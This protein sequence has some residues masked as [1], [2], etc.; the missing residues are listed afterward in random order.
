MACYWPLVQLRNVSFFHRAAVLLDAKKKMPGNGILPA[1]I[2][3]CYFVQ[4]KSACPPR[5]AQ[6]QPP[7]SNP[8]FRP[9]FGGAAPS[10]MER[11]AFAKSSLSIV[12]LTVPFTLT[13]M[14]APGLAMKVNRTSRTN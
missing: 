5:C 6:P 8:V 1:I 3:F 12:P 11:N 10:Q 4:L 9:G 2:Y 13:S 7:P 14:L